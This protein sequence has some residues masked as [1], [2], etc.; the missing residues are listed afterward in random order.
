MGDHKIVNALELMIFID[1]VVNLGKG[2]SL[3]SGPI[4]GPLGKNIQTLC[5]V[6]QLV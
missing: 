4:N 5:A 6:S 3:Q 1:V 2:V